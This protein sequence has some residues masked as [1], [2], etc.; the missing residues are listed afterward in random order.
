VRAQAP[1]V[2]GYLLK[3]GRL[4]LSLLADGGILAWEPL[5]ETPFET[6][7]D[8]DVEAAIL[9]ASPS[10]TRAL[11]DTEGGVVK[12]RYVYG[13]IDLNGDGRDEVLVYTLGPFFC[14]TG[15]CNLLLLTPGPEGYSLVNDFPIS[16]LPVVVAARKTEGWSDLFRLESGGGAPASYVRHVF[17]GE[18][19][20]EKERTPAEKAPEGR[21]CLTGELTFDK[22]M[23]EPR[24]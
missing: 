23:L 1:Y 13:R 12:G 5:D 19:Y 2:R 9:K 8:P 7:P 24:F 4:Y 3:D 15:G 14:G 11:V 10:Y 22:G 18:R 20:V 6:K 21:R 17:D 16:R